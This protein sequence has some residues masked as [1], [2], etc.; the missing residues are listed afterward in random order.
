MSVELKNNQFLSYIVV[1][2]S[3]FIL[4]LFTKDEIMSVQSNLDE[5]EQLNTQL[6]EVRVKQEDLQK[7]AL[8]VEQENSVTARYLKN[9]IIDD[10]EVYLYSEDK[11]VD[12]FYDYAD[13]IN[14]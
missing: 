13:N 8:E 12:Y 3:L 10:E 14:S 6:K 5:R 9:E 11:I 2:L 1:L 7:I 4:V